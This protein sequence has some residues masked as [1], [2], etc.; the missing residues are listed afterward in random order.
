MPREG[1]M[2]PEDATERN[3]DIAHKNHAACLFCGQLW[4]MRIGVIIGTNLCELVH[5]FLYIQKNCENVCERTYCVV[6]LAA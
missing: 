4:F 6:T 2:L 1:V 5:S 3:D